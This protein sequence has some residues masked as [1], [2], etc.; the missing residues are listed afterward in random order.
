MMLVIYKHDDRHIK[1]GGA[2]TVR[3]LIK[4]RTYGPMP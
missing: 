4:P 3:R 2:A 1:D